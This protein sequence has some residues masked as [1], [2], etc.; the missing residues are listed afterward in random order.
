MKRIVLILL[1]LVCCPDRPSLAAEPAKLTFDTYDG[2]F[3][4]NQFEPKAARSFV[5]ICDQEQ[6]D[7]VFGAAFVMGDKAHR[8]PKDVFK[9]QMVVTAIKRGKAMVEYKVEK[10]TETNGVVELRYTTAEKKSDTATFAC[11]LIVSIPK[12]AYTAVQFIEDGIPVKR[13]AVSAAA[14]K[15]EASKVKD[16]ALFAG[17]VAFIAG[18]NI[19]HTETVKL[20][21]T[22]GKIVATTDEVKRV[23]T[24]AFE[25]KNETKET[26][27]LV[28]VRTGQ[29]LDKL[30][31]EGD[32]VKTKEAGV[33]VKPGKTAKLHKILEENYE[34]LFAPGT[35]FVL[36]C[37]EPGHYQKGERIRIMV[38]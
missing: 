14:R 26:H 23:H 29:E 30:D 3:V 19:V 17:V 9:S 10:V 38:K 21:L 25:V 7:K 24:V 6:F 11:P 22:D 16:A 18:W 36:F 1:T 5:V 12:G 20:T 31:M 32:R 8:L 15:P 28:V 35:T 13:M 2:Y 27:Q 33:A 34:G 37:N 4:S